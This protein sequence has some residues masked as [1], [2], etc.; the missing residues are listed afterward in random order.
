VVQNQLATAGLS[1]HQCELQTVR[2]GRIWRRR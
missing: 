2:F 1:L